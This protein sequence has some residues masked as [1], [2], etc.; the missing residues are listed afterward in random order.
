MAGVEN[1]QEQRLTPEGVDVSDLMV[2]LEIFGPDTRVEAGSTLVERLPLNY[3]IELKQI[4]QTYDDEGLDELTDRML[5]T[6][7]NNGQP[8]IELVNP[9]TLNVLDHDQFDAFLADYHRYHRGAVPL[10][11]ADDYETFDGY[12][13]PVINGHRR[14]RAL[15]RKAAQL[16]V[17]PEN[18]DTSFTLKLGL[19]FGEAKPQQYIENTY[20]AVS[21]V[22]DA[23]AIQLHY[24]WLKDE[25]KD[26]SVRALME[27]FGYKD[28]KIRSALRF[29]QAPED[30]QGFVGN[31][32][33]YGN[34]V[35]LVRLQEVYADNLK[36]KYRAEY[37]EKMEELRSSDMGTDEALDEA[38]SA[39]RQGY[40][41]NLEGVDAEG[42]KL[43]RDYFE[44]RLRKL[45]EKGSSELRLDLIGAK[46]KEV[47]GDVAWLNEPLLR[48][49]DE[50][51]ERR[52]ARTVNRRRMALAAL[53]ALKYLNDQE[54]GLSPEIL[55]E[56]S[57]LV[58][59][60]E[61]VSL[62]A[63]SVED[64]G[65]DLFSIEKSAS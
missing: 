3:A 60:G 20:R 55:E 10:T 26:Y 9:P 22:E 57:M 45:L 49:Y 38:V 42:A 30:I 13:Y 52:Q 61:V 62:P 36:L 48:D 12:Y 43:M 21:P 11:T 2:G 51:L 33:S 28:D 18:V 47:K 1:K 4:R 7:D 25:G 32:L 23:R 8:H 58:T 14:R 31:G 50:Q 59:V 37:L 39:L 54:D 24:L 19:T 41:D 17:R 46:I 34:V 64:E 44:N 40:F 29:V 65:V 5:V 35:D 15:Y 6:F 63:P 27:V 16:G 56:L 53:N